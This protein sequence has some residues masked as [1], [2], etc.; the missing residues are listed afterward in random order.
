MRVLILLLV[1]LV[2]GCATTGKPSPEYAAYI[3][4]QEKARAQEASDRDLSRQQYA[5]I[6]QKCLTDS[7]AQTA[8]LTLALVDVAGTRGGGQQSPA[9]QPYQP[10]PSVLETLAL[11]FLK[12]APVIGSAYVSLVQSDNAVRSSELQYGFLG[13]VISDVTGVVGELQPN[14][15]V[16][17]NYTVGDGNIGGDATGDGA[18][19]GNTYSS[20]DVFNSGDGNAIGDGNDVDNSEGQVNGND[21]RFE[22]P[23]FNDSCNG[24]SGAPGATGAVGSSTGGG[25]SGGNGGDGGDGGPGGVCDGGG[26]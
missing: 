3:Q 19:V 7:C 6:A 24:A 23:D 4:F 16:A 26:G 22:S 10:R 20:A 14:V 21:N 25:S 8:L 9:V 13:G 1:L 12:I 17:G 11:G 15:T 2:A 5:K 18:G